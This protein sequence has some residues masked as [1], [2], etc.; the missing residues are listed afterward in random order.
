LPKAFP[1]ARFEPLAETDPMLRASF[2]GMDDVWKPR[3]RGYAVQRLGKTIPP[4]RSA[5]VGR[6]RVIYLPLDT[7]TGMLGCGAW[8]IFGYEPGEATALMKNIVLW[9]GENGGR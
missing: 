3:L 8:P 4:V 6:G 7:T 1:E 9:T 2:D 5:K